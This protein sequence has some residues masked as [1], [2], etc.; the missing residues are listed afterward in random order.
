MS[1]T[2][3]IIIVILSYPVWFTGN[4]IWNALGCAG[5]IGGGV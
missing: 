5:K 4:A 3:I 2:A 1:L